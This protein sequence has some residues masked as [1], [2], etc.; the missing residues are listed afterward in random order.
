MAG[1]DIWPIVH[2]ERAALAAD[3]ATVG[4]EQWSSPSQCEG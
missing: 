4:D 1:I 2:D 3:L